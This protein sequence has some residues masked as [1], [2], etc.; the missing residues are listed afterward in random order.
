VKLSLGVV[1]FVAVNIGSNAGGNSTLQS[2][3][4]ALSSFFTTFGAE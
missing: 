1:G 4:L 2:Y 3:I